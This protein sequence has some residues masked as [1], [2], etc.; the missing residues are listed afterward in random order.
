MGTHAAIEVPIGTNDDRVFITRHGR[1]C[2]I[3]CLNLASQDDAIVKD[4]RHAQ[5]RQSFV[6]Q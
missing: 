4:R 5:K 3:L 6:D 1:D 2:L